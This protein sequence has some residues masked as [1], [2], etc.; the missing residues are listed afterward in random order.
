MK[1]RMLVP[2]LLATV[3]AISAAMAAWAVPASAT[4]LPSLEERITAADLHWSRRSQAGVTELLL[5][6]L[7]DADRDYPN[8][9]EVLWRLA[10]AYWWKSTRIPKDDKKTRL[11]WLDMAKATGERASKAAPA[12]PDAHYWYAAA[13]A[14]T[15]SARGILQ[16]LFMVKPTREALERGLAADP[17]HGSC[18]YLM[19]ELYLQLPG[20]PLSIG[21]KQKAVEEARLSV[22][23]GP[24]SSSHW[25]VL[26]R[27]LIATRQY[28][29]AR[30]A[31][32]TLLAMAPDLGDPDGT[33][34]DQDEART[35]L[36]SIANK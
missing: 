9:G 15:G 32:N 10:R 17:N 36:Q 5:Q 18:H 13:M 24:D 7:E 2:A 8:Q 35:E 19:A 14:E 26:G 1:T 20:P 21:N 12:N 23:Y 29:E 31:L 27:A 11:E 16:S 6:N 30:Q 25:L 28:S 3:M 4:G 34:A 22:K 33:R